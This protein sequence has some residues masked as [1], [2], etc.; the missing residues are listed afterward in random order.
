MTCRE[1]YR[2]CLTGEICTIYENPEFSCEEA[3]KRK[4]ERRLWLSKKYR[5]N[6]TWI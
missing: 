5:H 6:R 2:K 1:K 4:I 3:V